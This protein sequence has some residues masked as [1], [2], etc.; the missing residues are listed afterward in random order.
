VL[1]LL[2]KMHSRLYRTNLASP[3][4]FVTTE[5]DCN[6]ID[7]KASRKD[8]ANKTLISVDRFQLLLFERVS[9]KHQ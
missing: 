3:E 5:F 1:L 8:K 9:C 4:L 6:F 2:V 7:I